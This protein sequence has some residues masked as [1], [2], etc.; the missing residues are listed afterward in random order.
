LIKQIKDD[1]LNEINYFTNLRVKD[2]FR[3]EST[4]SEGKMMKK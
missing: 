2:G 3:V 4:A 1:K